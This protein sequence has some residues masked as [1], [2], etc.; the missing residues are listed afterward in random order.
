MA[1]NREQALSRYVAGVD[2]YPGSTP[3]SIV[4]RDV[5]YVFYA[6]RGF[7]GVWCTTTPNGITWTPIYNL[8]T[9]GAS[10]LSIAKG[11]S[12]VVTVYKDESYLF[13]NGSGGEGTW[14]TKFD[15]MNWSIVGFVGCTGTTPG[16]AEN[17]SPAAAVFKDTLYVFTCAY[18]A[19]NLHKVPP[20]W[21]SLGIPGIFWTSF[22][23]LQ[24]ASDIVI[25]D[26][27]GKSLGMT[28][29]RGIACA[30]G[31]SPSAAVFNNEL[32]VFHSGSN[33]DGIWY[34]KLTGGCFTSGISVSKTNG[35]MSFHPSTSPNALV[36]R[37][38]CAFRLYWVDNSSQ[39]VCFSDYR[40]SGDR[41]APSKK[42]SCDGDIPTL[43]ANTSLNT[44]MFLQRPYVFWSTSSGG[45]NFATGYQ[46]EISTTGWARP[47]AISQD[48]ESYS[49]MTSDPVLVNLLRAK[50]GYNFS[51][52]GPIAP[53]NFIQSVYNNLQV[54]NNDGPTMM[55]IS[56]MTTLLASAFISSYL[57]MLQLQ[58]QKAVVQFYYMG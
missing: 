41:W 51:I 22:N 31:T 52:A 15:G 12:P 30:P 38:I 46:W 4:F 11:T 49:I 42:L 23:G 36:L 9:K 37:D 8:N 35:G 2:L 25:S 55:K 54:P 17:T 47:A 48:L 34:S 27:S 44:V 5:L 50:L 20:D 33:N 32:Y 13:F 28:L 18:Q 21:P 14:Y 43:A 53:T 6:G 56:I 10:F 24:W 26:S 58:P 45:I 57:I 1:L 16:F 7:D 19:T 3:A 29:I 39:S 40:R